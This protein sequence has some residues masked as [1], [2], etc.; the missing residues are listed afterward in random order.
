M[1]I[2]KNY[3]VHGGWNLRKHTTNV[4]DFRFLF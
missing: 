4:I 2:A 1:M 3:A